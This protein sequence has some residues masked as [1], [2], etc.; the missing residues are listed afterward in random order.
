M[1]ATQILVIPI[2]LSTSQLFADILNVMS[3]L[4]AYCILFLTFKFT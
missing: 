3:F 4:V 1:L 2:N